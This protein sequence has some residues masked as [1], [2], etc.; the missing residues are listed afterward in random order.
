MSPARL[1]WAIVAFAA[2]AA[3]SPVVAARD[4]PKLECKTGP[5]E[6][7]FGGSRWN[8]FSCNDEKTL[9]VLSVPESRAAPFYFVLYPAEGGYSLRGEGNGPKVETDKAFEDL[10]L[11]TAGQIAVLIADTTSVPDSN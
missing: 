5:I 4:T 11:L 10:K 1:T 2:I 7:T 8:I 9:V 3:I 6:R